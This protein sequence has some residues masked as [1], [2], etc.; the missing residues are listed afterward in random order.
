MEHLQHSPSNLPCKPPSPKCDPA[1]VMDRIDLLMSAYRKA[2]Y[3]DPLKFTAQL[4]MILEQYPQEV[5][6]HITSP[7]TGIQRRLKWPPALAEMVEACDAEMAYRAKVAKYSSMPPPLPRLPRP[8]YSVEESYEAM[9]K[10]YG[11]PIGVFE[12]GR[13]L[14]YGV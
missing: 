13:M 2:D 1:F 4:S 12:S 6:E 14:P 10:K 8:K 7:L 5:V 11:R 3:S 9:F